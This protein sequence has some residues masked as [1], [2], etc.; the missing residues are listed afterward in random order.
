MEKENSPMD[1][2][3]IITIAI[4]GIIAVLIIAAVVIFNPKIEKPGG[5]VIKT[6][7]S[8][9]EEASDDP[10]E[11]NT[12]G[13]SSEIAEVNPVLID[14]VREVA[15]TNLISTEGK[16]ITDTGE[17]IKTDVSPMEINAPRQSLPIDKEQLSE[18]VIKIDVSAAG[19]SP[20]SFTV[21][22]GEAITLALSSTD[23]WSHNIKFSD[24]S[25]RS[26]GTA[27]SAGT[28]RAI[29]FNAPTTP[30]EYAFACD[31]PGH[32]GRGEVGKMIVE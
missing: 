2:K 31:I 20:N 10:L 4:V 32:A 24:P 18:N 21:K 13:E 19:F 30:G 22:T 17:E 27:V 26:A 15:G 9:Q 11:D 25:L 1:K 12:L 23:Q 7:I 8:G 28:T 29:S 5:E 6:P 14:A 16:V 3:K